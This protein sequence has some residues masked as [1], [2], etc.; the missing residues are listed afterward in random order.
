[1]RQRSGY[2]ATG[3]VDSSRVSP[4]S[5]S[6][7]KFKLG[8]PTAPYTQQDIWLADT[9]IFITGSEKFVEH[10]FQYLKFMSTKPR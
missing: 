8:V 3:D 2:S 4:L 5:V 9:S 1:M 10:H 6:N 7:L